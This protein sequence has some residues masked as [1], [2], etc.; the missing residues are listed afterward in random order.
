MPKIPK[1]IHFIW[2]GGEKIMPDDAIKN[3]LAWS[4]INPEFNI[5]IWVDVQTDPSCFAKYQHVLDQ[6]LGSAT[7]NIS[8]ADITEQGVSTPE[9]RYELDHL[10]PNYGASS[11]MLRYE[12]LFKFG[13][14]YAD[15][16]DV[17]PNPNQP[18]HAIQF[19]EHDPDEGLNV[20]DTDLSEPRILLHITPHSYLGHGKEAHGTEA[21]ICTPGHPIM[22]GLSVSARNAY[23]HPSW[24]YKM[25]KFQ[26]DHFATAEMRQ[27][28]YKNDITNITYTNLLQKKLNKTN[29][30][31]ETIIFQEEVE[32]RRAMN[33]LDL[34][35]PG[36]AARNLH[37]SQ[38]QSPEYVTMPHAQDRSIDWV[39]LPKEHAGSWGKLRIVPASVDIA[40][41]KAL[42]SIEFE[43]KEMKLLNISAQ[44]EF[45][46]CAA[47]N[48]Q[49]VVKDKAN[50]ANLRKEISGILIK[51]LKTDDRFK[52]LPNGDLILSQSSNRSLNR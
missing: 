38:L 46:I 8:I 29:T 10:C 32:K 9:I 24:S 7:Q 6:H 17:Y 40:I 45:I 21:I 50:I 37:L 26:F 44:V 13:G 52:L 23:H 1:E 28:A 15:C 51:F 35:G 3:V 19:P 41:Q 47:I 34:T 42:K 48:A 43:A 49:Q 39:M 2:A 16:K 27:H 31:K 5:K 14:M 18:L 22:K 33:T 11:D 12:I 36:M 30:V 4:Q 25:L 20:F